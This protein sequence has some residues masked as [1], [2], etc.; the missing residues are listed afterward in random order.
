M[1]PR[2]RLWTRRLILLGLVA[3]GLQQLWRHG[4]DYLFPEQFAEVE[5]G[6][7]YRGAW[8]QTWPMQQIVRDR[9]IKTIIA[10][11]HPPSHPLVAKEKQLAGELGCRWLHIPIVDDRADTD[12]AHLFDQLEDA[13]DAIADAGNQPVFFHCHHGVNR[14]SMAQMA[15]RML[16]CGWTLEQA[17]G[18]IARTFGLKSVE[19]GPDYHAMTA[20]YRERVLPRR[21]GPP[22]PAATASASPATGAARR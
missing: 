6:K 4:H 15:Y 5:P 9:H 7:I 1:T 19:R 10:L 14:A 13:A 21:A 12:N 3:L 18:E 20:F 22:A 2:R 16:H 8:Q 11:A 17:T